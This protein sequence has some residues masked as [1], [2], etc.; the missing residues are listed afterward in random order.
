MKTSQVSQAVRLCIKNKLAVLLEGPPGVGKSDIARD[1]AKAEKA[2]LIISHPVVQDPT[3]YKGLP[4]PDVANGQANFLP[5]GDLARLIRATKLTAFMLDDLGHAVPSVQ[6]A[7]MQ[8]MLARQIGEHKVPDCVTFIAA[9]NGRAHRAGVSGILEPVKS[10]FVTILK[11]E[12]NLE[13]WKIWAYGAG[14]SPLVIGFVSFR[15]ELFSKFVPTADMTNSPSP[16]TWN[17]VSKLIAAEVPPELEME[18]FSGAVGDAAGGEFT[19]FMRVYRDL[20]S[21]D[22]IILDPEKARVPTEVSAL[23][24]TVSALACK[25]KKTNISRIIK[26]ANRLAE[27]NQGEFAGFMLQDCQKKC[28]EVLT[29]AAW[30]DMTLSEL[31]KLYQP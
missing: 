27:A 14:I 24:A 20:P 25:A 13:D 16:R 22:G 10:R 17:H 29:T 23:W 26:Y 19:G 28:P 21:I 8:L 3:D 15:P 11:V 12:A 1:A 9:T 5:F 31:G 6:A 30:T 2:E 18:M 7:C 4:W